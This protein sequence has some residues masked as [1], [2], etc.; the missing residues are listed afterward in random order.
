MGLQ[1][2]R[3]S[4]RATILATEKRPLSSKPEPAPVGNSWR[5]DDATPFGLQPSGVSPAPGISSTT[6]PVARA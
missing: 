3:P 5:K 1:D 4:S 2:I 6:S